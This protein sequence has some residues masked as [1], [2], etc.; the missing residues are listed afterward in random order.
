M[1]T[2]VNGCSTCARGEEHYE[3][4]YVWLAGQGIEKVQ[5]DYRAKNGE[6]F[7]TIAL[8]LEIARQRRD[9]WLEKLGGVR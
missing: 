7:S 2:D 4:F 1:E 6:L 5:Y 8:S 9:T 3:Y